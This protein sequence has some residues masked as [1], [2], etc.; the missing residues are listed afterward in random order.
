MPL[1]KEVWLVYAPIYLQDIVMF[2]E[3]LLKTGLDHS[4]SGSPQTP[5]SQLLQQS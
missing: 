3:V 5:P 4:L 1:V 2:D